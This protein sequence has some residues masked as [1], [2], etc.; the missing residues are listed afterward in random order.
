MDAETSAVVVVADVV[1]DAALT[2]V[3]DGRP[4][5]VAPSSGCEKDDGCFP[6][7]VLLACFGAPVGGVSSAA[8]FALEG[9]A[10]AGRAEN[11]P[12]RVT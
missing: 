6:G 1:V 9:S 10:P 12:E 5:S 8:R 2:V 11:P 4:L 3:P 7:A